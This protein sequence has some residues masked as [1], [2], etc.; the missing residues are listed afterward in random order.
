[1]STVYTNLCSPQD[2]EGREEEP[3]CECGS[4]KMLLKRGQSSSSGEGVQILFVIMSIESQVFGRKGKKCSNFIA[5]KLEERKRGMVVYIV[6][7]IFPAL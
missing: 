5:V 7:R 6:D 3:V 4:E 2:D 1:M